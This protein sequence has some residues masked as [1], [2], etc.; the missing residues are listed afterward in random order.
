[1]KK[2]S[3]NQFSGKT[4]FYI[5]AS[6]EFLIKG[7]EE[8]YVKHYFTYMKSAAKLLGA[9]QTERTEKELKETLIFEIELAQISGMK[10]DNLLDLYRVTHQVGSNL[11]LSLI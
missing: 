2:V 7:L 3:E 5:I 9:P 8:P 1:M 6:R 4:Y 11:L 10:H